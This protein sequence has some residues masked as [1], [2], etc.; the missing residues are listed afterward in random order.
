MNKTANFS[1][2]WEVVPYHRETNNNKPTD[3]HATSGANIPAQ[4]RTQA[5]ERVRRR[6]HSED[7]KG[8]DRG[9]SGH[10]P[11]DAAPAKVAIS[12]TPGRFPCAENTFHLA[13]GT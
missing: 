10:R 3:K 6:C 1:A 4:E 12:R 9:A 2:L 5:N 13:A 7:R 8:S 11:R